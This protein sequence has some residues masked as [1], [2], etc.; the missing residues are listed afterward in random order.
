VSLTPLYGMSM[1]PGTTAHDQIS[2]AFLSVFASNQR[3]GG[4]NGLGTGLLYG[5]EWHVVDHYLQLGSLPIHQ[6]HILRTYKWTIVGEWN[7]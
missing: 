3:L 7:L 5:H 6:Y 1:V 4:E 2:Q